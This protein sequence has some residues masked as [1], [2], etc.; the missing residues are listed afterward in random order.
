MCVNGRPQEGDYELLNR[1]IPCLNVPKPNNRL[2][3]ICR[4]LLHILNYILT[5]AV[6]YLL[7]HLAMNTKLH[8]I[9]NNFSS[10]FEP[11]IARMDALSA[12]HCL[13]T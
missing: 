4:P 11:F 7:Y 9:T 1:Y 12:Y 3:I 10:I 5:F 6:S 13:L 2:G 8:V